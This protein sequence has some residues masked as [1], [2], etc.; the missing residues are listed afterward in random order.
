MNIGAIFLRY[1]EVLD[2]ELHIVGVNIRKHIP[3]VQP[4]NIFAEEM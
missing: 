3:V 4:L 2:G 1:R